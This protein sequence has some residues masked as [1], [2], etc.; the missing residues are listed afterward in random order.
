MYE[1]TFMFFVQNQNELFLPF[2]FVL[3]VLLYGTYT[4][5]NYDCEFYICMHGMDTQNTDTKSIMYLSVVVFL[6]ILTTNEC[7]VSINVL[8]VSMFA[9]VLF[10]VKAAFV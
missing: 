5:K 6:I 8:T 3:D 4:C 7:S 2:L 9:R 1:S 10:L